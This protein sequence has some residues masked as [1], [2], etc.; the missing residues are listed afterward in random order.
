[1]TKFYK[2]ISIG[3]GN[4]EYYDIFMT[5]EGLAFFDEDIENGDRWYYKTGE[6]GEEGKEYFIPKWWLKEISIQELIADFDNLTDCYADTRIDHGDHCEEGDVVLAMT[7]NGLIK[8][9]TEK[10]II[11][12]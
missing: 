12:K 3:N 7:K 2:T 9:L 5:D 11:E 1:M 8:F 4:P 6:G 10:G